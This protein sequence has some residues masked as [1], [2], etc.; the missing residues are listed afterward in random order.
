MPQPDEIVI[1]GISGRFPEADNIQQF[2]YNLE[3]KVDMITE[4]NRRWDIVHPE[5]PRRSGKVNFVTKFDAGFFGVHQRQVNTMD[6]MC[7]ML[8]ER[9][10]EA[11]F[12]AGYRP[13]ELEGTRT[14]VFIGACYSET[15]KD[16]VYNKQRENS[17]T[18]TG[19]VWSA[20]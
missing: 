16:V 13:E 18:V 2:R 3:N 20:N 10:V 5:L 11:I 15:E 7:R 9:A 17:F 12:D 14:G 8:L 1:S 6:V 19:Y 4:D